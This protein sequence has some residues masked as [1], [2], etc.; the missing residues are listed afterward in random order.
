MDRLRALYEYF[1]MGIERM[2]PNVP[3]RELNRLMLE[4]Q[5]TPIN[6]ATMRF[7]FQTLQQRWVLCTT[8]WN[9]T[10][11]E[12]EVGTY[13][14]DLDRAHRHIWPRGA[15]TDDRGGG[16]ARWASP[17]TGSRP[18]S[19]ARASSRPARAD[20]RR[21]RLPPP[22]PAARA[23]PARQPALA[24]LGEEQLQSFYRHTPRPTAGPGRTPKATAEQLRGKLEKLL[25]GQTSSKFELDVAVEGGKVKRARQ[26]GPV[27][28]RRSRLLSGWWRR[29]G[30]RGSRLPSAGAA[31][32]E[33]DRHR[34]GQKAGVK[35]RPCCAC[36]ER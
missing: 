27:T 13:R 35:Q 26:A 21:P 20:P 10:L 3:R 32:G 15:G 25:Q 22:A 12:I 8:Y 19:A 7:R 5:Q 33:Q 30:R 4:M 9:R 28:E 34:R 18:S 24:R 1:F 14:R 36:G 16:A 29:C 11:R 2:P 17:P 23:R 31:G 6:N